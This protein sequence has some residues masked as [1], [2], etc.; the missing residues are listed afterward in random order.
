MSTH[1][2]TALIG[3]IVGTAVP[4]ML[5]LG[6]ATS[7]AAPDVGAQPSHV[8]FDPQPE[9]PGSIRGFDPQPDP[10]RVKISVKFGQ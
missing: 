5:F 7:H 10:P 6:A 3:A 8:G 1:I 2:R 9:P 4:A